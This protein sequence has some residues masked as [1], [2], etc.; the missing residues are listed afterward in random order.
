M[1]KGGYLL[2]ILVLI[3]AFWQVFFL[4]NGMKWD[5]V[6]AF[7]PS[8]YFFSES[9]LNNQFPLW[10]PYLLYGTPIYADLV[11]VFN[12]EFWI[13]GNMF[14]YSNITLQYVFL[15]YIFLAGISF[16]YFLK[17]FKADKSL[18]FGLSVAYMLS[19]FVIGHAQHVAFVLGYALIPFLMASYFKFMREINPANLIQISIALFLMIYCSYPA[20]TIISGYFLL[21]IFTLYLVINLNNKIFI[22][23]LFIYHFVLLVI[24]VLYSSVLIVA[25][26][27]IS[28][29][30]TRFSG[31]PIELALKHPFSVKSLLSFLTPMAAGDDAKYF[32]TD[33]SVSNGY[34]GIISLVLFLLALTKKVNYK[35]SYVILFFAVFSLLASFGDQFFLRGFLF[36]FA[37]FM[38]RFQY[39]GLFRAFFIFGFLAFA[40]INLKP[41][42]INLK[43]RKKLMLISISIIAIL[44]FLVWNA[45]GRIGK[46][47]FFNSGMDFSDELFNATR[48]DNIIFQ[49]IIQIAFLLIFVL[50]TIRLK[51]VKYF[52]FGLLILIIADGIVSTQLSTYYSVI[53]KTDPIK[54]YSYLKSS[55]KGFPVPD[56]NPIEENSDR[57]AANEFTW[58]NN[59]V[60][61][62][63]ITFD[64]LVS[65]KMD[66]YRI[67]SDS[68]PDLLEAI[69]SEPVVYFSD[70]IRV[71]SLIE[72]FKPKTVFLKGSDYKKLNGTIFGSDQNDKLEIAG[73]SPVKIEMETKTKFPQLLT[74]QQNYYK[75]WK[76]YIDGVEK[77]LLRSNFTHMSVIVPEGEHIVLFRYSNNLIIFLFCFTSLIFL[78]LIALAVRYFI[79]H[80]PDRKKKVIITL[81]C[82]ISVVLLISIVNRYLYN[83]NKL[84]L[85]PVI[86]EKV[87]QWKTK[88]NGDI[89]ILLSTQQNEL[90]NSAYADKT[91]F[92]NENNNVADLSEFLMNSDSKYFAFA[93]QG[94]I[95][96]D[97]LFELI[98]S[99]YPSVIE[100]KETNNSGFILL[101]KFTETQ[102]FDVLKTFEPNDTIEWEQE[103]ARIMI[104]S[105]SQNHS[106]FYN[107]NEEFGFS[108]EFL[109]GQDVMNNGKITIITDFVIEEKL[110]ETLLV[111]TTSR[112]DKMQIYK[113]LDI[114]RFVKSPDVWSRA[115]YEVNLEPEIREND[116]IKIYFWNLRR[117][118]FQID[119]LKIKYGSLKN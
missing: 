79:S 75:G 89:R 24:V 78:V 53:S 86:A 47:A 96:G 95:V 57:N 38:N 101:E 99:F 106:Y 45:I 56:L 118:K 102:N 11:S 51:E 22:R 77:N 107:E 110:T 93:W 19:G 43:E 109:A 72:N 113:T 69:K 27:Q 15:A 81:V 73:F 26:F 70:D 12:P 62:K 108:V 54:F 21:C 91:C 114:S 105:V 63:K 31:L 97:D 49:G 44:I 83:K 52:S 30:L 42:E 119:N 90:K 48:Y 23:K 5:F 2:L 94:S 104:D 68:H 98:Y 66:G 25:Y 40:G 71:D 36:K 10:N 58:M 4:Q 28:T 115:V 3:I 32:E 20:L 1:K 13:I 117:A 37:P 29:Y 14:G 92:I 61:P 76:V 41:K 8:R 18:S 6:D 82:L 9:V 64:G 74:Y 33:I 80:Y 84:G 67:I 112:E 7:L 46:F 85:A 116:T 35:E 87:E 34:W 55:P 88:Y 17:Q 103:Q 39:P 60:F 16:N 50:L 111:F 65:F 59:N 100:F